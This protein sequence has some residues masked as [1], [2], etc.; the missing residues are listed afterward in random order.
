MNRK[1][2]HFKEEQLA[3]IK[4]WKIFFY[5]ET[6]AIDIHSWQNSYRQPKKQG[7]PGWWSI[8]QQRKTKQQDRTR[9]WRKWDIVNYSF[10]LMTI[11]NTYKKSTQNSENKSVRLHTHTV[12]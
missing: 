5:L 4:I 12:S 3:Q 2:R 8:R 11:S 10:V 9:C 7:R 6:I 1:N